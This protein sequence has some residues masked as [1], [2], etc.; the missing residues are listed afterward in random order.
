MR[1]LIKDATIVNEGKSLRGC[2]LIDDDTIT[3]IIENHTNEA[4]GNADLI[5]DATGCFVIPGVID[6]HVHFR[7]PGLTRKAD[8]ESESTA[9]AFGGVTSYFDM[10]NTVP[11]TTTLEALDEK[12]E[13]AARESHVNYSFFFGATNDN[14]HLFPRLDVHRIPG[15]K[16]FM[17][18]STGNMLVDR[19]EALQRIFETAPLPIMTHCEDTS[20]INDN[21]RRLKAEAG[22]ADDLPVQRHPAIR[23]EEACYRSTLTAVNLARRYGATLHVAHLSTARELALFGHDDHITAEAVM[24][25]LL[26][27]DADYDT[28]GTAIK[29]NPAVKS[30]HDRE[31]LRKALCDGHI[32]TIAT[33]HAPHLISDK[34]GGAI[35]AASGMPMIQ[36][37]LVAGLEMVDEGVLSMERL[38]QLMCHRPAQIFGVSQRGFLRKGY[39]ADIAIVERCEPWTVTKD[40]IRSKCGWSPLEGHRFSWRVRD[41]FCNGRHILSPQGFDQTSRGTAINFRL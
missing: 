35:K 29:C 37:S 14:A 22:D 13:R 28:R 8:I 18:S 9:A 7:E 4:Y 24:A 6:E 27:T 10:P 12:F 38:V 5:V 1:T 16:L 2:V 19:E 11:Q 23:N 33:D 34:Q 3:D 30:R 31:A 32:A 21:L 40:I 26:F 15:I 20:I 17:G 41:V 39:K 25:H 36:F